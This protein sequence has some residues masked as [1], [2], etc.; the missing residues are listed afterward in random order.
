MI[1][2]VVVPMNAG[3][4]SSWGGLTADIRHDFVRSLSKISKETTVDEL[5]SAY[6]D[7]DR[8]ATILYWKRAYWKTK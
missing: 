8:I 4:L 5:N 7:L 3:V 1:P 6:Q 2:T